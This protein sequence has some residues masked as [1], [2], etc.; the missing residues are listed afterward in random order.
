MQRTMGCVCSPHHPCQSY[1]MV[2]ESVGSK[3]FEK[4]NQRKMLRCKWTSLRAIPA[5]IRT[6][7]KVNTESSPKLAFLLQQYGTGKMKN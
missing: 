5:C 1:Q 7:F 6:K 4:K 3:Y 2:R